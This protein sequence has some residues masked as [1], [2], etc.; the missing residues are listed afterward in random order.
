MQKQIMHRVNVLSFLLMKVLSTIILVYCILILF[1]PLSIIPLSYI[2][3]TLQLLLIFVFRKF[4]P[5]AIFFVFVLPYTLVAYLHFIDNEFPLH[6]GMHLDFDYEKYYI[7]TFIILAIFWA[8]FSMMLPKLKNAI[9]IKDSIKFIN[10][11]FVFY[12]SFT[13]QVLIFL[14][15]RTGNSIFQSG[16]YGS[17]DSTVSN[18]GGT[19]IFEYF[20]IFYPL[21]FVFSGNNKLKINMLLILS[22]I[23]CI[24]AISFG[25][26]VEALQCML[27]IFLLHF[28]NATTSLRKIFIYS[29]FPILFFIIFGYIRAAPNASFNEIITMLKDNINLAGYSFFGNQIDVFY[30]STRLYGLIDMGIINYIDR[31]QILFY[32]FLAIVTPYSLLPTKANMALFLQDQYTAGG[33][34]LLPIFFYVYISYF[35]V[36]IIG[37]ILGLFIRKLV[38][39]ISNCSNYFLIYMTMLMSTYPRWFAYSSNV[40]Y[41][42]CF[43]SVIL[44][45]ITNSILYFFNKNKVLI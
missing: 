11:P 20:L 1:F 14:F 7:K 27:I 19:A 18:L 25:G 40:I 21:S 24:K 22:L 37:L 16:G 13:I 43:Y 41:K 29:S 23:Y 45:F 34:G 10:Q 28:D 15:G 31:L 44:F 9:V 33:G 38:K 5:L 3:L 4:K 42:F 32:N 26:R 30:S 35:G 6:L 36:I 2:L 8:S 39:K 17:S 12:F